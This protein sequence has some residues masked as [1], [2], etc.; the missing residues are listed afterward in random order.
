MQD[1]NEL[2][3]TMIPKTYI[4]QGIQNERARINLIKKLINNRK[5]P[6]HG[7]SDAFIEQFIQELSILD[8]NN[9]LTNAGVGEREGR[10]FSNIVLKRNFNLSHGIGRSGDINEVQPKAAGSS[11]IYKLT[12]Y[13][14][15]HAL[16]I[17]GLNS[18]SNNNDPSSPSYI[19]NPQCLVL[20]LA[21]GM[22]LTLCFL[23]IAQSNNLNSR[24]N[25]DI[26][27][28]KNDNNNSNDKN[29]N[30]DNN[31]DNDN[32]KC[33]TN[34]I[35]NHH[36]QQQQQLQAKYIIW[37]RID[38]KSCFKSILT[39]G[40]IPLI[41][42]PIII[43]TTTYELKTDIKKINSLLLQYGHEILCILSTTSCFAPRQPDNID[44][45][46]KLCK[47]YNIPHVINNAYGLQCKYVCKLINRGVTI[48]RVDAGKN[49][50]DYDDDDDHVDDNYGCGYGDNNVVD[51][52]YF[53][54]RSSKY[55]DSSHI[56]LSI[57]SQI[58]LFI[59]L[60]SHYLSI[61]LLIILLIYQ[62]IYLPI[63]LSI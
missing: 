54:S 11:V 15:L 34:N 20:P 14:V 59:Y 2:L 22:T 52:D 29:N 63:Y 16:E 21:T 23:S 4:K 55:L 17:A 9:F 24:N 28:S 60:S 33:D 8:S 49:V 27:K 12:T 46:A 36:H 41:V 48:G 58:Y 10:I 32:N 38:Q 42:D 26:C 44:E 19:S 61:Y 25:N 6:Q 30:I 18:K 40:Y 51:I 56:Y 3:Q 13:M 35:P 45:I 53:H 7:W 37:S 47:V 1:L 39:A 43:N 50:I 5:L 57:T 62:P 31:N